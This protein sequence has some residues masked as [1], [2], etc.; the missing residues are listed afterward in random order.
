M[1]IH[2]YDMSLCHIDKKTISALN[3]KRRIIKG[4]M[5][6][7]GFEAACSQ[8]KKRRRQQG[9]GPLDVTDKALTK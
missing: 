4:F 7:L 6:P 8:E 1:L 9:W 2:I 3:I 5:L